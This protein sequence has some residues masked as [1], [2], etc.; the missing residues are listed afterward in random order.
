[1]RPL[2]IVIITI[3]IVKDMIAKMV[4]LISGSIQGAFNWLI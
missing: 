4:N 3:I 1:M 2:L